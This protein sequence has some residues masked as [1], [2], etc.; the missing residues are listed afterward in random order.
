MRSLW[1]GRRRCGGGTLRVYLRRLAPPIVGRGGSVR[2]YTSVRFVQ[3]VDV[4][5][6]VGRRVS[7]EGLGAVESRR[8]VGRGDARDGGTF[9][10]SLAGSRA[11]FRDFSHVLS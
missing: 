3:A 9:R 10:A 1:R 2:F 5:L 6:S 4:R 8:V 7:L 11:V